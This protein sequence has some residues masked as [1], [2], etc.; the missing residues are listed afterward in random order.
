M[1]EN[2]YKGAPSTQEVHKQRAKRK[3]HKVTITKKR[4]KGL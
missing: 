3:K 4:Y 1:S 2:A